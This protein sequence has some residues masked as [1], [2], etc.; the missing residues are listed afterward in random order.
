[1]VNKIYSI[2]EIKAKLKPIFDTNRVK[3]AILFGSYAKGK[4]TEKSDIDIF[5]DSG[6]LGLD[7]I[8]L[9]ENVHGALD[10]PIDIIDVRSLKNGSQAEKDINEYGIK[11]YG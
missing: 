8:G 9:L 6:L 7:F 4:A 2:E 1:M 10:K 3:S 11:I 5:V